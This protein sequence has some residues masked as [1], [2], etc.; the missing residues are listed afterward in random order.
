[1]GQSIKGLTIEIGGDTTKLQTALN[2]CNKTSRSLQSELKFVNKALKLDPSNVE[3]VAQKEVLLKEAI[4]NTKDKLN[5][6]KQAQAQADQMMQ[7]GIEVDQQEYRKLQRE[8]SFTKDKLSAYRE[9]LTGTQIDLSRVSENVGKFGTAVEDAGKKM[10]VVSTAVAAAGVASAKM[11]S[12]Y[13]DSIAKVSTIADES[14]VSMS[15]M[16]TA[17]RELSDDTGVAATDIAENVYNAISAG[18]QTG[19]AVSFVSNATTLARAGFAET[20]DALDILT[21][22]MNAYGLEAE[23]VGEVSDMLI[24]TQNKGKTTVAELASSMGKAIP[25][26]NAMNVGLDQL[27]TAYTILTSK[28]IKTAESTTYINSMFNELGDSATDVGEVINEKTGKSFQELM[29]DGES[30]GDTLQIVKDYAE[31]NDIAFNE[32]WSSSEAGKAAMS[33]LSDGVDSFNQRAGE[34]VNSSGATKEAFDKLDTTSYQTSIV[35]GQL[36]NTVIDLGQTILVMLAPVIEKV[37]KKVSEFSGWFSSLD[38]QSKEMIVKVGGMVVALGPLLIII[39]KLIQGVAAGI[40]AI[41]KIQTAFTALSAKAAAAGTSLGAVALPIVAIVAA[42]GLLVAA[43]TNLWK[44]NGEFK[45]NILGTWGELKAKFDEFT[46]GIVERI[47]KLGFDFESVSEI[48]K[49]VWEELCNIL[50]PVFEG[51]FSIIAA[52]FGTVMDV[53]LGI[54]DIFVGIFTGDWE[55]VWEGVKGIFLGVWNGIVGIFSAVGDTLVGLLDVICGWFGTTWEDTWNSIK[56]FF[57]NYWNEM[58][59]FYT[60][61]GSNIKNALTTAWNNIVNFFTTGIPNFIGK[62]VEWIKQLPYQIGFIIGQIIGKVIQF[63]V[64]AVNWVTTNVP[65][66]IDKIVTFFSEL[67]GKLW[68]WLLETIAK[69]AQWQLDMVE[70][71]KSAGKDF[72]DNVVTFIKELPGNV[73]EWLLETIVKIAEW[74]EDLKEKGKEAI[75]GMIDSIVENAQSIPEKMLEIGTN[76]VDGVWN[77]IS[78]AKDA[79]VENVKGFFSGIVDGVKVELGIQSPSRVFA[80]EVGA[81]IPPGVS[82]GINK[83]AGVVYRSVSGMINGAVGSAKGALN[84]VSTIGGAVGITALPERFATST[85][86]V[87]N[88]IKNENKIDIH[89]ESVDQ[90]HVGEIVNEINRQLG[91]IY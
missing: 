31:E 1:M 15:A 66:I 8:I 43:F 86:S 57:V 22:I 47:N 16:S 5:A 34:M 12:D 17:I 56:E 55:Q 37:S 6:L 61:I 73:K 32:L 42:I 24:Q 41:G 85:S 62:V 82:K 59:A 78:N 4:S 67:P 91:F 80:D 23:Q 75:T 18:Q 71:A 90:E 25:T 70:K 77:G 76:I 14:E 28:G 65:I 63:G 2:K 49:A 33:L 36:K 35:I 48:I 64:D 45:S 81:W 58:V 13:E 51:A 72:I 44:R 74:Q 21:T 68:T 46:S 11:A 84:K 29:D 19:D 89:T 7:E 26:A 79:F 3:L 30:L 52:V 87:V 83:T 50:A 27:T 10:M 54:L 9:E 88:H 39:G 60:S 69:V 20:G 40:G 53:I 38:Q